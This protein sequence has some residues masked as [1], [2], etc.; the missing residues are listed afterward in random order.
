VNGSPQ[1]IAIQDIRYLKHLNLDDNNPWSKS[2]PPGM[3]SFKYT[4]FEKQVNRPDGG[5]RF[6]FGFPIYKGSHA[7]G[8]YGYVSVAYDFD[9]SRKFLKTQLLGSSVAGNKKQNKSRR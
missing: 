9:S 3:M 8:N 5:Q 2:N 6:I 7:G 4:K 1:I